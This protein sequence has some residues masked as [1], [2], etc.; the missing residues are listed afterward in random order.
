METLTPIPD[1][2]ET[3]AL[4]GGAEV[5]IAGPG[6]LARLTFRDQIRPESRKT[7]AALRAAGIRTVMLTGDHTGVAAALIGHEVGV[8]EVRSGLLPRKS[9]RRAG[10]E[11]RRPHQRAAMIGDGVNDAP[12]IAAADVEWPWARAAPTPPSSRPKSS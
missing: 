7:L 6:L 8:D 4:S 11:K 2:P 9:R 10:T 12:C 3:S 1:T 5:W